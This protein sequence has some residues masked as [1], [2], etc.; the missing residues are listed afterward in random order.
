MGELRPTKM[1]VQLVDRSIKYPVGILENVLVR[2]GQ[3]YIPTDFI[4]MDIKEDSTTL[5]Y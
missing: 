5:L 1:S 3:F 4:I 2:I